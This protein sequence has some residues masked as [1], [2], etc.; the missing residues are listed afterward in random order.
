MTS[1]DVLHDFFVPDMRVKHDIIPGRYTEDLVHA[2]GAGPHTFHLRR[3]LRQGP[4][5][6]EGQADRRKPRGFRQ[7]DGDRRHRVGRITRSKT[8]ADWGKIQYEREGLQHLPHRGRNQEQ[9]PELEGHL[10]Q[11][12]EAE[13]RHHGAGG[14]GLHPRID[15]AAR[16]PKSW[17]GSTRSCP[18]SRA[19]CK[20]ESSIRMGW[21]RYIKSLTVSESREVR[22]M[23]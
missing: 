17:R 16:R 6:H 11:D 22:R 12:G 19:C 4:L 13:Q 5:R 10:G 20:N 21:S 3:V 18:R 1:E 15:D 2:D 8:P 9:G 14:R 7:V 23:R